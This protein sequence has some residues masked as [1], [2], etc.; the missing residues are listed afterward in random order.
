MKF[1]ANENFPITSTRYL[2]NK[3]FDIVAVGV[4]F[5]GVTDRDVI[6]MAEKEQRTIITFDKDYGTLIFKFGNKPTEG[7]IYLRLSDFSAD[8]PGKIIESITSVPNFTTHKRL[9]VFDGIT[10]RQREY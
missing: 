7:V 3:G 6:E 2:K 1:L 5:A 10:I 9:T 4:D 8:E